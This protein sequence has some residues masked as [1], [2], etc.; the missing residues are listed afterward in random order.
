[1]FVQFMSYLYFTENKFDKWP[2][3]ENATDNL[4]DFKFLMV[5]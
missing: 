1:M 3:C 5:L 4:V 2:I